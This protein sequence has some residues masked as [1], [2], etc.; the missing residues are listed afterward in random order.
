VAESPAK[1][2]NTLSLPMPTLRTNSTAHS[3]KS[4]PKARPKYAQGPLS[5]PKARVSPNNNAAHNASSAQPN[6]HNQPGTK[7]VKLSIHHAVASNK[8]PKPYLMRFI[9][10]PALGIQRLEVA[11]TTSSNTPDPQANANSVSPPTS[12]SPVWEIN[13]STPAKGAA[14]QG[15]TMRAD[16]IPITNTPPKRPAGKRFKRPCKRACMPAGACKVYTSN[17]DNAS[18]ANSTAKLTSTQ[19]LCSHMAK[20]APTMPATTPNRV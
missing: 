15:P 14:T 9:Q 4:P 16:N 2:L 20:L 19:G 13:S 18:S 3:A 8:T 12:R 17:M 5:A 6:T 1:G 11:P 10:P 7:A